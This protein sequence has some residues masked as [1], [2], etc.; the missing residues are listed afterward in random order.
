MTMKTYRVTTHGAAVDIQGAGFDINHN[1]LHVTDGGGGNI[2]A[3]AN[4]AW[5]SVIVVEPD[6]TIQAEPAAETKAAP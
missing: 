1:G 2:A 4:G 6:T 3:F 5:S